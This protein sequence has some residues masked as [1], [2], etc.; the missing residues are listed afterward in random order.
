V[1]DLGETGVAKALDQLVEAGLLVR[2][3]SL[4]EPLFAFRH[5][6]IQ[7]TVYNAALRRSRQ[8]LHGRLVAALEGNREI[9]SW[10][11]VDALAYHAERAGLIDKAI[12]HF[13]A[14]GK[15]SSARS[16]MA[17]A[18]LLLEHA[19]ELCETIKEKREREAPKLSAIAALGPVLTS[20][21]GSASQRARKLYEEGVELARGRP[22]SER[23]AL[24]PIYWGWWFTGP[25]LE[26][27]RAQ[28]ILEELKDVEDSEVQ[29]QIRH[30]IWAAD[31]YL[32]RHASCIAAVEAGIPLYNPNRG[33]DNFTLFGGHDTKVCG[34]A[35]RGLSLWLT[36]RPASALRSVAE[37][38][39]WAR[40]TGHAASITHALINEAALSC[41][42]RDF[43]TLRSLAAEIRPLAEEHRMRSLA[44][45][46]EILV[47]WADGNTGDLA[48]G[49]AM[50]R[51]GLDTHAEL[52][53][54]EDFPVWC[55]MLAE[56]L[57]A[58]GACSEGLALLRKAETQAETSGHRYWLA[59][60]AR[61]W[62]RL[63]YRDGADDEA[64]RAE[65]IKS[66]EVAS[67][68]GAVPL[69]IGAYDTLAALGLSDAKT[70]LYRERADH[71]R[72]AIE[73]GEALFVNAEAPPQRRAASLAS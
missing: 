7:E 8:S 36:G 10:I 54:P 69:L 49:I 31:F 58:T 56:L 53:T 57:E 35:H 16:A 60:L 55:C 52:E 19:L 24:F 44:A 34:L 72:A 43:A 5:A 61:R 51:R 38:R 41:F 15:E 20:T 6:L 23:A 33:R 65:L 9:A 64:V 12:V 40:A 1:P 29:L 46:L 22:A 27:K 26:N 21:E 28:A 17:E 3:R 39:A 68:Q 45:T 59:E 42:R 63:L 13:V 11:G 67:E 66:L 32:G 25:D 71:A 37:A 50:I 14:A 73:P 18:R 48:G 62:A 70:S 2:V 47:G 4:G 30:C